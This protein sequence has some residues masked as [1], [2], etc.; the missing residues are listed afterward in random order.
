MDV[1]VWDGSSDFVHEHLIPGV[2]SFQLNSPLYIKQGNCLHAQ[3][4]G[5]TT[6]GGEGQGVVWEDEGSQE[7]DRVAVMEGS[8]NLW[9]MSLYWKRCCICRG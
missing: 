1:E 3:S 9:Q 4:K 5:D 7:V 6:G 8:E 2:E